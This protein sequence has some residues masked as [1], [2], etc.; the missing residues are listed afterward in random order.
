MQFLQNHKGN[1]A[2]SCNPLK[3]THQR[4]KAFANSKKPCFRDIFEFSFQIFESSKLYFFQKIQL[5]HFSTLTTPQLHIWAIFEKKWSLTYWLTYW[6]TDNG[7]FKGPKC[8]CLKR[9]KFHLNASVHEHKFLLAYPS[10]LNPRRREKINLNFYFHTSLWCLKRFYE[11]LKGLYKPFEAPQRSVKQKL[12]LIFISVQLSETHGTLRVS[13]RKPLQCVLNYEWILMN[14]LSYIID[15][16]T[17]TI[18][19]SSYTV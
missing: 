2:A 1:Y 12:K 4:T 16:N 3:R 19:R 13:C 7:G 10:R 14:L 17:F 11:G 9:P 8:Q 6:L 5:R 15:W 18:R